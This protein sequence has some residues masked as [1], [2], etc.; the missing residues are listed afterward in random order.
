MGAMDDDD[1]GRVPLFPKLGGEARREALAHPGLSWSEW[2]YRSFVR[3][4]AVLG[5]LIGDVFIG[6][7]FGAPLNVPGLVVGLALALY[8]EWLLYQ[9]LWHT[10]P[11]RHHH[12]PSTASSRSWVFPVRYGRWTEEAALVRA[13][14]LPVYAEIEDEQSG[15]DPREFL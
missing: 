8:G 11:L 12:R 9:Y 3:T 1:P 5:F 4:W 14:K 7:Y 2:F 13:G 15:P 6:A 10:P